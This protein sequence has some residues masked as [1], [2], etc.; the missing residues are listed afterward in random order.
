M[1][2]VSPTCALYNWVDGEWKEMG[3]QSPLAIYHRYDV[4]LF[5]LMVCPEEEADRMV[6]PI[7]AG[8]KLVLEGPHIRVHK[9][10]G[11]ERL[12]RFSP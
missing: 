10:G 1:I 5:S 8:I 2:T 11:G 6:L 4:P 3:T 7:R 9:G 12:L